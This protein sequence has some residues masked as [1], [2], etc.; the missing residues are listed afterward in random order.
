M[1][2]SRIL[3]IFNFPRKNPYLPCERERERERERKKER[4][5]ERL[6]YL[7]YQPAAFAIAFYQKMDCKP[8]Q[9]TNK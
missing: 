9:K 5:K 6:S 7:K 4:D 3:R 1:C 8:F 2:Y